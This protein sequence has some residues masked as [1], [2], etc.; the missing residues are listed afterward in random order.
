[1]MAGKLR[2]LTY[3]LGALVKR[4]PHFIYVYIKDALLFDLV[5]HT[6]THLRI[7]K[8]AVGEPRMVGWQDGLLYVASFTS[9]IR[10]ALDVTKQILGPDTFRSA[11]FVDL[12]CGKGKALLVY[13]KYFGVDSDRK[14]IGIEYDETLCAAAERNLRKM[15][16]PESRVK[17]H[18][19][20]AVFCNKYL[21][22][23]LLIVYLYNSFQGPTLVKTLETLQ[24]YPHVLVYVDPAERETLMQFEYLVE[25]EHSGRYH[26]DTWLIALSAKLRQCRADVM[27]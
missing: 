2:N 23:G 16:V 1:M 21:E 9:V 14:A 25:H 15:A 11:Q 8:R 6:N 20:S 26:A 3:M 4:G 18:C 7:P 5:N 10:S 12:G 22:P 24:S 17:V 19:D 27:A 13:Y